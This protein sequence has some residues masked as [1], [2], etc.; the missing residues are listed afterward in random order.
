MEH[1]SK[2]SFWDRAELLE[3]V[4]ETR[5]QL[6]GE[7]PQTALYDDLEIKALDGGAI[8]EFRY[9][10]AISWQ[11]IENSPLHN[12]LRGLVGLSVVGFLIGS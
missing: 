1:R 11:K 8:R 4:I 2:P 5:Q 10:G 3:T 6:H 9:L 12:F 7:R